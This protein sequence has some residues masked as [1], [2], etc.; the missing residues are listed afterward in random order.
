MID[1]SK[2]LDWLKLSPRY[3][4][5][6]ALVTGF[7]LFMP[8]SVLDIFGV[9]AFVASYR[10]YIGIVFLISFALILTEAT[11]L[12]YR[13]YSERRNKSKAAQT[14]ETLLKNMTLDEKRILRQYTER[15]T[16]TAYFDMENGV[17]GGLEDHGII[18]KATNV[19]RADRWAY[20]IVPAVWDYLQKH[21]EILST[22]DNTTTNKGP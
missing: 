7:V 21:P 9:T 14:L 17:V 19:G 13:K 12:G 5:P 15:N 11:L 6:L 16:K 4:F 20:N 2:F 8:D 10:G 3:L 22:S 18:Y 1:F